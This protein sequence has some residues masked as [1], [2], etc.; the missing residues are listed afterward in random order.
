VFLDRLPLNPNGKLDRRALPAPDLSQLQASYVAPSTPT[1]QALCELWQEVLG[2]ERVGVT[3][4]FF[5]LGGHSLMS[6]RF[7]TRARALFGV[8]I[9]L[10]VVFSSPTI[11]TIAAYID[12]LKLNALNA[13]RAADDLIEEGTL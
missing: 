4:N 5:Q 6:V 2:L 13:N 10:Q 12:A 8:D 9:P 11:D 1:E 3:D 7:M